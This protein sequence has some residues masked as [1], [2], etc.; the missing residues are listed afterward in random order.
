[1][2]QDNGAPVELIPPHGPDGVALWRSPNGAYT[3][4]VGGRVVG[5][6]DLGEAVLIAYRAPAAHDGALPPALTAARHVR[7]AVLALAPQ[8]IPRGPAPLRHRAESVAAAARD[9]F[10]ACRAV[11]ALMS[12]ALRDIRTH[13]GS[14]ANTIVLANGQ[15]RSRTDKPQ[16]RAAAALEIAP[17]TLSEI[18]SGR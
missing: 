11:S 8:P 5:R 3:L 1:M 16:D 14:A 9:T 10:H 4:A 18:L 2:N 17:S 13:R 12:T 15:P 7:A 6:P